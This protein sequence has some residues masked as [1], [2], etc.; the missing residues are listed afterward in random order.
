[1]GQDWE[2]IPLFPLHTVL[3][4]GAPL[5]LHIFEA[6][7]QEMIERCVADDRPFGIV[8]IRNGDGMTGNP[9]PFMVGT[10][11]RVHSVFRYADGR[12]DVSVF[13]ERRFRVRR[14]DDGSGY[15]IG[16]T[17]PLDE[18]EVEDRAEAEALTRKA[19]DSFKQ[20]VETYYAK[21][22]FNVEVR[23]PH[24]PTELS[25]AIANF[26]PLDNRQ[27]QRLLETTSTTERLITLIPL[28][29]QRIMDS[30]G[31]ELRRLTP[32]ALAD[33]IFTN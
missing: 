16:Q 6:R 23:F 12:L 7:Y 25:F 3:F 14:L 22:E 13:G 26:L 18:A 5:H 33:W 4:P 27:K 15:M 30:S 1:M 24:E 10:A 8:L 19:R 17:E 32:D 31:S 20:L 21:P 29:E 11:A 2:E 28:I 9:E